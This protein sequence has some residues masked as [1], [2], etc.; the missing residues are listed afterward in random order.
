MSRNTNVCVSTFK[1][2]FSYC[3]FPCCKFLFLVSWNMTMRAS[4]FWLNDVNIR[5]YITGSH[6][7]EY[8][9]TVFWDVAPCSLVETDRCFR[10]AYY[11]HHQGDDSFYQTKAQH[12]RRQ[13]SSFK[14]TFIKR[15]KVTFTRHS[16]YSDKPSSNI[17]KLKLHSAVFKWET[18]CSSAGKY[19]SH[20]L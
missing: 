17:T 9:I 13:S 14:V 10:D 20:L 18:Y 4:W 7:D 6:G 16:C 19:I 1:Q 2:F 8:E 5:G 3:R 12:P 11:L 15:R